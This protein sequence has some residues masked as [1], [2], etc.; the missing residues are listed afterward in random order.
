MT[1]GRCQSRWAGLLLGVLLWTPP[2]WADVESYQYHPSNGWSLDK[3]LD[4]TALGNATGI[5]VTF[6]G[7]TNCAALTTDS[8]G[9]V[10]CSAAG[11]G[12]GDI[13][14]V[15]AGDGMTGGGASGDVT[16]NAIGTANEV[17][18]SANAIGLPDSVTVVNL[19]ASNTVTAVVVDT[20][21][22]ENSGAGVLTLRDSVTIP[23]VTTTTFEGAT[24]LTLSTGV[25]VTFVDV[26]S[27]Q[28]LSYNN[29]TNQFAFS[30]DA[31]ITSLTASGTVTGA[32]VSA[33]AAL[34]V[35]SDYVTDLTGS[36]LSIS[37]GKLTAGTGGTFVLSGWTT[38]SQTASF[39]HGV[40]GGSTSTTTVDLNRMP[41]TATCS[42]LYF[43]ISV[44]PGA[45]DSWIATVQESG[46]DTAITC[47]TGDT[48][49]CSDLVNSNSFDAGNTIRL[50][51]VESGTATG[52]S[53]DAWMLKC[54]AN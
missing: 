12:S 22:V 14:G 19:T 41:V 50:S 52:T 37:A 48:T 39:V 46:S 49:Q 18:V 11:A 3:V 45:G 23:N 33:T 1:W 5:S 7:L 8:A 16:L 2:V 42:Q 13:T 54:I 6:T 26:D 34:Q 38:T 10:V 47:S 32:V 30:D 44:A 27:N 9:N 15:T 21:Y 31:T 43:D 36:G 25:V 24:S 40:G 51:V 35:G 4:P 29:T 20:D 28:T 53:G 17:E